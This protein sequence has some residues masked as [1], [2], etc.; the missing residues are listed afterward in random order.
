MPWP[1]L[2][3]CISNKF[4]GGAH[5]P[6]SPAAAGPRTPPGEEEA[7][8]GQA[9]PTPLLRQ[10]AV[11]ELLLHSGFPLKVKLY[12][13]CVSEVDLQVRELRHELNRRRGWGL[14]SGVPAL[15][16]CRLPPVLRS[17]LLKAFGCGSQVRGE[18]SH[19]FPLVTFLMLGRTGQNFGRHG[20]ESL[21]G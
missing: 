3:V 12:P 17:H 6:S 19:L 16:L 5:L 13:P 15:S 11:W 1:S 21:C 14:N 18:S 10:V 9:R 20:Q 2:R 8:T 4:P 7:A